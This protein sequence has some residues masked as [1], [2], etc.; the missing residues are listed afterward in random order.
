MTLH[1]IVNSIFT[2]L[3]R[4]E[5]FRGA[6]YGGNPSNAGA[7]KNDQF[8]NMLKPENIYRLTERINYLIDKDA[9]VYSV[10]EFLE[11]GRR[12]LFTMEHF[13]TIPYNFLLAS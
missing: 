6:T 4:L 10:S 12:G 9:H 5:V 8:V 3:V 11:K 13:L 2:W 1:C 7:K